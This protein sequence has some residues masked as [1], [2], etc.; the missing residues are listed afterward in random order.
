MEGDV[1]DPVLPRHVLSGVDDR[2]VLDGVDEPC[3]RPGGEA[4]EQPGS[5][6]EVDDLVAL[7]HVLVDCLEVRVHAGAIGEHVVV[8]GQVGE[9]LEVEHPRHNR[10]ESAARSQ[11]HRHPAGEALRART[12]GAPRSAHHEGLGP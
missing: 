11:A 12:R 4:G 8:P 10:L 7:A 9:V 1:R 5:G 6:P 3:P 2:P